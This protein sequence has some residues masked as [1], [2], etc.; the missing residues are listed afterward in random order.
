MCT[1]YALSKKKG[2]IQLSMKLD[3]DPD[4]LIFGDH[5]P[6]YTVSVIAQRNGTREALPAT[7][8]LYLMQTDK[9]LKPNPK[10]FS[11]NSKSSKLHTRPEFKR[12]RCIIPA[13]LFTESQSG[14]RPHIL[15]PDDGSA[16]AFG[17]IYKENIDKVTGEVVHSAAIITLPGHPALENIHS[18][19]TP[20]ML[21]EESFD[22]WL[23]P[24]IVDTDQF[25]SLL[26]PVI[27]TPLRATP[28]DKV[29][30]KNPIG[31]SFLIG[32]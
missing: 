29:M 27:H 13:S 28:V 16:L 6:G 5:R 20:M 8:W 9:G 26:E 21:S 23:D 19:S 3:I 11:V 7:W 32:V 17:G 4:L 25:S 15:E 12:S 2:T 1:N 24:S 14:K 31:D 10:Y 30:S 22:S 18:K